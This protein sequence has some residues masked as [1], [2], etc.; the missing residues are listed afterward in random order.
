MDQGIPKIGSLVN[1]IVAFVRGPAQEMEIGEVE[2]QLLP[3]VMAVGRAALAEFVAV[4]GTGY[5]GR[6]IVDGRGQRLPYVRDRMCA[7]RSIF[8]TIPIRRAYYQAAGAAGIFPLDGELNLPDRGYSYV[9]QE[10]SSRL[11]VTTSY[12]N[13]GEILSSFFPVNMPIRSLESIVGDVCDDVDRY[14]QEKAPPDGAPD[15]VVTVATVDKKGIVIRK[16]HEDQ[17]GSDASPVDSDKPGKK[18]MATV[19]STYV[20]PRHVRTAD[21]ILREVSDKGKSDSKPKPENKMTWGS[22]TEGPETTVAR[23]K[24]AVDQRLPKG[25]ELVC[26][27]D[28]ERSLWALI[29][30]Y[31]PA[32]FFVLD[33][34]HVLEH[35]G[36]A[37]LCF[38][39]EGGPQA[40]EFVT[41][42][43]KMLLQGKAGR[44]IGGLKQML[45]KHELAGA[46]RHTLNQ[47]IG[48]LERNRKHMRYEICLTRGYPIGS[49][50]IEGACRN[51]INDRLELTGMSWSPQGAEAVMRLRAVHLNNDWDSFWNYRRTSERKRL[52][53]T[54]HA[55]SRD[56]R[57]EELRCAA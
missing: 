37:A 46:A 8:G 19:I 47:V 40:R 6:E 15:A 51:L 11:A 41:E 16:P 52:Y 23:L 1:G 49:G 5:A 34:F 56:I 7:Y 36:K 25:N 17:A 21:D 50:V 55:E 57:E 14:Y 45:S 10:L 22:L 4:K 33:I 32:A 44:M 43:L 26:I 38:Y 18:K 54:Q 20:S 42:R 9:V 2:R 29:C 27:L 3:L 28:G 31:F 30:A 39:D 13:A 35:L 12:E 48:Y 24:K 53:A